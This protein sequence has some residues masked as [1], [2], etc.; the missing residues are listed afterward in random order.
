MFV[1]PAARRSPAVASQRHASAACCS[2]TRTLQTTDTQCESIQSRTHDMTMQ[3]VWQPAVAATSSSS[4]NM[5]SQQHRYGPHL[6]IA[7][8]QR[9][10]GKRATAGSRIIATVVVVESVIKNRTLHT[11]YRA[12][13]LCFCARNAHSKQQHRRALNTRT[14]YARTQAS[15]RAA[16]HKSVRMRVR[17]LPWNEP[18]HAFA[19]P[20]AAS[21]VS[22][23]WPAV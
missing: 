8:S 20:A 3:H 21:V 16:A 4:S 15:E 7:A 10:S 11:F 17:V 14:T 22:R 12:I 1:S 19:T 9:W 13:F 18:F 6:S 5:Q 23:Y 2:H